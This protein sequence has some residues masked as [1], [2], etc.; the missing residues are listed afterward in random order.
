M[1]RLMCG[2]AR[3]NI[4]PEEK[5]L[6]G[7]CGL[8][9]IPYNG[10]IDE[11]YLR[12]IALENDGEK[13]LLISFDLDKAPN[14]KAWLKLISE[15]TGISEDRILYLAIHTH[16]APLTTVRS[17]ERDWVRERRGNMNR[18]E[19]MVL[20]KLMEAVDEA[21]MNMQ[22]AEIGFADAQSYINVHRN[23]VFE[24][25]N[26]NGRMEKYLHEGM[27][28]AA[29]IDHTVSVIRINDKDHQPLAFFINYPVHCCVMFR[30]DYDGQG[31]MG[32]SSD[33]GGNVSAAL[34][35]AYPG[36]VAMWSSGAAGNIDPLMMS[37]FTYPDF[38][39]CPKT[40]QIRDWKSLKV[41]LNTQVGLHCRDIK[42]AISSVEHYDEKISLKGKIRWISVPSRKEDEVKIRLQLVSLGETEIL[43]IGGELYNTYARE[44]EKEKEH[45]HLLFVNHCASMIADAN[46][47]LD[48]E[49]LQIVDNAMTMP[50]AF[51]GS[52]TGY[53]YGTV[54]QPLAEGYHKLS[55]EID[56]AE[57]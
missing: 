56:G 35:E 3:R 55:Q 31:N 13:L 19:E 45:A 5:D 24:S 15:R 53:V 21:L 38:D 10:I 34:E 33:I 49:T 18:Y 50:N 44:L 4:T 43:G 8:M 6:F 7:L 16:C 30:N 22:E 25:M 52:R 40:E 9:G 20:E 26:E 23:A 27:N 42:K 39:G 47:I 29:E 1:S 57:L 14:P 37:D 41:L 32:I 28:M 2:R 17:G 11:L 51:P 54:L 36:A 46:Y 12:V 48:D